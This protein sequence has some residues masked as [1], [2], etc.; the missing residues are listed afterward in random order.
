MDRGYFN[1]I[2]K[3]LP[4]NSVKRACYIV[5][6][7]LRYSTTKKINQDEVLKNEED[8][9]VTLEEFL[10]ASQI[11]LSYSYENS[12]DT[13]E[14]EF[15]SCENDC[16]YNNGCNGFCEGEFSLTSYPNPKKLKLC[17]YYL[18]SQNN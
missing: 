10:E 8:C 1:Y 11:L 16:Q 13:D 12:K 5:R 9:C 6:E 3:D 7:Y 14:I 4:K 18:D 2:I 17:K 15:S